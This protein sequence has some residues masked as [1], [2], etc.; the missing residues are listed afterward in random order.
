[1]MKHYNWWV[2]ITFLFELLV[3]AFGDFKIKKKWFL[4]KTLNA[5]C[6]KSKPDIYNEEKTVFHGKCLMWINYLNLYENGFA[7][8]IRENN[9]IQVCKL[10]K[11]DFK[12]YI[13][14]R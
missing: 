11:P 3:I 2:F 5:Y 8:R 1:M 9:K 7:S 13:F 10:F 14:Y 4:W 12:I 6:N